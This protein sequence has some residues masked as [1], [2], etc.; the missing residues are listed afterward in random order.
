MRESPGC[1]L[2]IGR[3]ALKHPGFLIKNGPPATQHR[4]SKQADGSGFFSQ[5][6]AAQRSRALASGGSAAGRAPRPR[7]Q[8]VQATPRVGDEGDPHGVEG[9]REPQ[10]RREQEGVR[11]EGQSWPGAIRRAAHRRWR[12]WAGLGSRD[13]K[14]KPHV[15]HSRGRPSRRQA[16][17]GS[18]ATRGD[19]KHPPQRGSPSD[20]Q[21]PACFRPCF[22]NPSRAEGD[23]LTSSR[24]GHPTVGRAGP[25]AATSQQ[26]RNSVYF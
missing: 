11:V 3:E 17:R 4:L 20:P 22:P 10:G 2:L 26:P 8:P 16:E 7:P 18:G 1:R 21:V 6:A 9:R 23:A 5:P 24:P 14:V 13:T 15:H 12:G 25:G 19:G